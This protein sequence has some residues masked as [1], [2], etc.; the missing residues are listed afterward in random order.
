MYSIT[1]NIKHKDV[2]DKITQDIKKSIN[3]DPGIQN[4]FK[5]F[6]FGKNSSSAELNLT[7]EK[8]EKEIETIF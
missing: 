7:I 4:N 6:Q 8:L 3:E 2:Y 5:N 1:L